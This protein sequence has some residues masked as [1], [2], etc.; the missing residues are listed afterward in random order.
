MASIFGYKITINRALISIAMGAGEGLRLNTCHATL[1]PG[2][3]AAGVRTARG[4][5]SKRGWRNIVNSVT[6][7]R[8]GKIIKFSCLE[9]SDKWGNYQ[10]TR[11]IAD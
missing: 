7:R 5:A 1:S 4:T 8:D 2:K 9:F 3:P 6:C 11:T 10:I